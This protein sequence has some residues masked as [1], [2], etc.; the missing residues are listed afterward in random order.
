MADKAKDYIAEIYHSIIV[1]NLNY[2]VWWTYKKDANRDDYIDVLSEYA[3]FFQTSIHAHFVAS[4]VSLYRLYETRSRSDTFTIPAA[5]KLAGVWKIPPTTIASMNGHY[6]VAKPLWIKICL[7]RNNVFGHRS[8]HLSIE[9]AFKKAEISSNDIAHLIS[10]SKAILNELAHAWDN[11]TYIFNLDAD[12][13]LIR[14]L[15]DLKS[16]AEGSP[17]S[18]DN[19]PVMANRDQ[20]GSSEAI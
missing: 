2:Q 10:L 14:L 19:D 4:I 9:D 7:L 15:D 18:R 8:K 5:I 3:L 6:A 16:K 1:A 12:K 17:G 11:T 20:R 13:D